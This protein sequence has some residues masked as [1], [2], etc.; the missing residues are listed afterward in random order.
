MK[1]VCLLLQTLP[2]K[3]ETQNKS[4]WPD[5]ADR[6]FQR[7]SKAS[8][9]SATHNVHVHAWSEAT[10]RTTRTNSGH[11]YLELSLILSHLNRL[12]HFTCNSFWPYRYLAHS[13][14]LTYLTLTRPS[15]NIRIVISAHSHTRV[16]A[17]RDSSRLNL[18]VSLAWS[19]SHYPTL[20][21]V[22]SPPQRH[23]PTHSTFRSK[24]RRWRVSNFI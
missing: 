3:L 9:V 21:V 16:A 24:E 11:D 10:A 12:E 19:Q 17:Q 2:F 1:L 13:H 8:Q 23:T 6:T 4:G 7:E 14:D 5:R 22:L 18:V 15:F 20:S